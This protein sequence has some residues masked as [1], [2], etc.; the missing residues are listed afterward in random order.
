MI[1]ISEGTAGQVITKKDGQLKVIIQT[2]IPLSAKQVMQLHCIVLG[3]L[4]RG[5][6]LTKEEE[7]SNE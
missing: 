5:N 3:I 6:K 7:S 1:F 2:E 4:K